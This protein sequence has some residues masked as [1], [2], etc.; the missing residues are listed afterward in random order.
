MVVENFS[1]K[2]LDMSNFQADLDLLQRGGRRVSSGPCHAEP[3][4]KVGLQR[5]VKMLLP[6][7][8]ICEFK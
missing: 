4:V 8:N 2:D 1:H 3:F 7:F 6:G 5:I